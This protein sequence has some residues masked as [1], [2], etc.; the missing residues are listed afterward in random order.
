MAGR[1]RVRYDVPCAFYSKG[2]G[3]GRTDGRT[4]EKVMNSDKTVEN[5]SF[6]DILFR[7]KSLF[8]GAVFN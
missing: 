7:R 3:D 6:V 2:I 4:D 5:F 8:T 1:N